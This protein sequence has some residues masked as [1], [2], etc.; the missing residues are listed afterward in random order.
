MAHSPGSPFGA[1]VLLI[2]KK[3]G[4]YRIVFDYRM[5][6]NL[7][8]KDKYP[9]PLIDDLLLD[10]STS[11]FFSSFDVKDGFYNMLVAPEDQ[12]K[13]ACVTPFGQFVWRVMPMGLANAP[14]IFQRMMNRI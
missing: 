8:I 1:P 10:L 7:T 11:K 3:D 6:N 5:L 9:L 2:P 13:T 4:R 12:Y 14:S